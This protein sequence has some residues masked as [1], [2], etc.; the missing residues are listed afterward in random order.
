MLGKG[1]YKA[2]L[3]DY[4]VLVV[5]RFKGLGVTKQKFMQ[6]MEVVGSTRHENMAPLRAYYCSKDEKASDVY[7][8]GVLLLELLTGKSPVYSTGGD[9]A[10]HLVR[11]V[12]L[13]I[14]EEWTIEVFDIVLLRYLKIE[15]EM[16]KLLHS[17]AMHG[18]SGRAETENDRY[19]RNCGR[20]LKGLINI[21]NRP[22][23]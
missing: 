18:K 9:E 3:E 11:W 16:A 7:S 15:V 20:Y 14:R 8:Y 2:E 6:L 17:D 23:T 5:R 13:V 4:T 12:N 22:S 10:Y 21:G 19:G 1:T